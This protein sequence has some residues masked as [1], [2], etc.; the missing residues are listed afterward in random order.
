M[1]RRRGQAIRRRIAEPLRLER[2]GGGARHPRH[3][4]QQHGRRHP[5]R[6]G[7]ARPRPARLLA[8]ALRRRRAAA[9][10]RA[11][12]AARHARRSSCRRV[13]A[14]SP[15][16]GCW[17]PTSRPSSRAPAC[18]RPAP[19]MP[20]RWR[21]CSREL[22]AEAVAWLDAEG[23]PD[24]ARRDRLARQPALPAPGLRAQRALG[25]RATSPRRRQRQPWRPSTG[26]TSGSTPSRRRI[27]R[28]RSSPCGSTRA[29]YFPR[30]PC[31]S[32]RRRAARRRAHRHASR[33]P[34][35]RDRAEAAIY[36]RER[37]GA[38]ARIAGPAILTQL[39]ATTLLL[40]GQVGTVDRLGNLIIG[41]GS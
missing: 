22:E 21:A 20:R 19:S 16:S 36:A 34:R 2:G 31:A 25:V 7:R 39:D 1:S 12:A 18:R 6:V 32:C 29:A 33:V 14:C 26:C 17:S 15:R 4:R 28:S 5:R 23:V 13:R 35:R 9:R 11:G 24:E 40:P 10:R 38:G 37:L 30:R 3:R 8:A 41:T 27:R